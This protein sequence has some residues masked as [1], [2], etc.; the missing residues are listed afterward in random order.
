MIW[1]KKK[2]REEQIDYRTQSVFTELMA[3]VD[4]EFTELETIQILNNVRRKLHESLLNKKSYYMEQSVI[5][6]QKSTEIGS[7]IK[8][9]E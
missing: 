3:S 4:F 1:F 7:V 6:S 8:Y 5:N 2:T 9:I